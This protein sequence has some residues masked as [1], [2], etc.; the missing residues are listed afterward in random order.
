MLRRL[1]LVFSKC[2]TVERAIQRK[3]KANKPQKI[4]AIYKS[5][6]SRKYPPHADIKYLWLIAECKDVHRVRLP[7][8]TGF[9]PLTSSLPVF[10]FL[11][12]IITIFRLSLSLICWLDVC[13]IFI[14]LVKFCFLACLSSL[15][16]ILFYSFSN[17]FFHFFSPF[18]ILAYFIFIHIYFYIIY[19]F[20]NVVF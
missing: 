6:L 13:L 2:T 11:F 20:F 3:Y 17:F 10:L 14:I 5:S 7:S 8:R 4:K 9:N 18:L 1:A 15:P 19:F 12:I 16:F